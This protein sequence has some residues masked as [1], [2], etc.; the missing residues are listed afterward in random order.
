M[1]SKNSHWIYEIAE[2]A[3]SVHTR[4]NV[5]HHWKKEMQGAVSLGLSGCEELFAERPWSRPVLSGWVCLLTSPA[6]VN[7]IK[8][9]SGSMATFYNSYCYGERI[10]KAHRISAGKSKSGIRRVLQRKKKGGGIGV[11]CFLWNVSV[12]HVEHRQ[13]IHKNEILQ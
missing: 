7:C 12:Q 11:S 3:K 9:V 4:L 13:H 5:V 1:H 2:W 8:A 10:S 6:V